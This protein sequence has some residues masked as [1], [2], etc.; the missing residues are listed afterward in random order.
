MIAF[1]PARAG[2]KRIKNKNIRELKGHPL[3][4]YT[5]QSAI[6]SGIFDDIYVSSDS[7]EILDISEYYGAKRIKRPYVFSGD[8]VSDIFWIK[9]ALGLIDTEKYS[10]LRP[11]SPLRSHKT[12][13]KAFKKWD[14]F[15]IMK[16]VAESKINPHKMWEI[17][18]SERDIMFPIMSGEGHFEQTINLPKYYFQTGSL[19]F[20]KKTDKQIFYQ[21]YII[22][23]KEGFD[24]NT[25]GDWLV[26]QKI[27][28]RGIAKLPKIRRKPWKTQ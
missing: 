10:I 14:N 13:I 2:S 5:I 20:R 21:P 19:E 4:A 16:S 1:I 17:P 18:N 26:L 8:R 25:E 3:I 28:D 24:L 6:D 9:H 7:D 15:S 27:I 23:K 12:I 22:D 11:T